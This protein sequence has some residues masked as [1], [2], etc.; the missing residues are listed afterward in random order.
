M[1]SVILIEGTVIELHP[2][3]TIAAKRE[4]YK[5]QF[6]IGNYKYKSMVERQKDPTVTCPTD[7]T[8]MSCTGKFKNF[9]Y[10]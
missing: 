1:V 9:I 10:Y 2:A 8:V 6:V 7:P 4:L 5:S 3:V